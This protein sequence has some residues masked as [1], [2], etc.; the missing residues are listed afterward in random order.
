MS[1]S[2]TPFHPRTA[3]RNRDNAWCERN[4]FTL[5]EHF[6]DAEDEALS[7]RMSAILTDISWRSRIRF[8]GAHALECVSRLV[9]RDPAKLGIG[10]GFKALWLNDAGAVRGAGVVVRRSAW[11]F[12]LI[13]AADD[14]DW[15]VSAANLFGVGVTDVTREGG[16]IAVIGPQAGRVLAAAGLRDT[17]APLSCM[18][19]DW[20]GVG[21]E[22]SRFGEHMG[23]EIWCAREDALLV[24]DRIT[25]A[26]APFA[27]RLAGAAAM[28]T[29]DIEA[30]VARPCRDFLPA[31]DAESPSPTPAQLA[32][33]SL[34]DEGYRGFNGFRNWNAR[35][36]TS[37]ASTLAGIVVDGDQPVAFAPLV[38]AR[39]MVGRTLSSR[40]SPSLRRTIALAEIEAVSAEPGTILSVAEPGSL[41]KS[42]ISRLAA[43]VVALPFLPAPDSIGS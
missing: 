25:R 15:I 14:L 31:R 39:R 22:I 8:S 29:L 13:S 2:A 16:A 4:G 12:E 7:A 32:L 36:Q 3:E 43:Y 35:R 19:L 38:Q 23:F 30:G 10:Q 41:A 37:S 20:G 26:G 1:V 27:L 18:R 5:A 42:G 21:V 9:T 6:G 34:I 24:W 40:Y 33:E 17:L 11:E 28:N